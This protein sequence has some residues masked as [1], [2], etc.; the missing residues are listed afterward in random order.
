MYMLKK[1][2]NLTIIDSWFGYNLND[3]KQIQYVLRNKYMYYEIIISLDFYVNLIH[4][5]VILI[6]KHK[7]N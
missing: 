2:K 3:P 4:K 1:E 5:K 6:H 7:R